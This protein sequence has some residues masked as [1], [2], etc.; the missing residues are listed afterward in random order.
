MVKFTDFILKHR[1]VIITLSIFILLYGIYSINNTPIDAIPDLSDVQVTIYSEWMGQTPYVIENQLTYPLVSSLLGISKV[2]TVRGLSMPNYSLVYVIFEDG[3]DIYWARSRVLE[4]LQSIRSLLPQQAKVE[5]GP[6]AT[7]V[8]WVYQY[9][10]IS[11]NRTLDELWSIQNFTIRYVLLSIPGVAEVAS[12]GGFEKEYRVILKPEKLIFYGVAIDDVGKAI[13]SANIERGGKYIEFWGREFLISLK[14][15]VKDKSDIEN[16][17]VKEVNGTPIKIKDVAL[18][19]ETPSLRMGTAD[20]NGMGNVVGGIVIMRYGANAYTIIHKVKEK[21]NEIQETFKGDIKIIPVYDRSELIESAVENLKEVLIKEIIVVSVVIIIFLLHL[22]ASFVV[23]FFLILSV[24]STFIVMNAL[25]ITSNIMSL[26]GIAVAIGTIV[27][28]S[29]VI[30]E[31]IQR[32]KEEGKNLYTSIKESMAEVGKPIFFSLLIVTVSFVPMLALEGH[33]KRLFSPLVYTKTFSML[34]AS[35]LSILV[36]PALAAYFMKGKGISEE[37]NPVIKL[38]INIYR[39]IYGL[40][41]K[42]R[43]LVL[44]FTIVIGISSYLIYRNLGS[45]FMPDLREGTLLYMPITAPGISIDQVQELLKIQS[46]IIKSFP[47]VESVFGKAGRANTS[48][49]PAPLSMIET[50]IVL[51][52]SKEWKKGITYEKIIEELDKALQIPGVV[53]MWTQP[54]KGRIDM[55]STGIRTPLGI[56]VYGNDISTLQDVLLNIESSL[57]DLDGIISISAQRM[58]GATY[59]EIVPD[60]NLL[61]YYGIKLEDFVESLEVLLANTPITTYISGR[62]RY[63]ITVG[64][65]RDYRSDIEDFVL[66][67]NGKLIPIKAIADI[68]KVEG[69]VEITSENG[70]YVGNIL[71]T[72]KSDFDLDKIIEKGNQMIAQNVSLPEGYHYK[73]SGQYEYWSQAKERLTFIVPAVIIAI[74]LIVYLTFNRLLE[75]FVVLLTLPACVFGGFLFMSILGYKISLGSIGGFLALLGISAE[76]IIIM[77]IYLTNALKEKTNFNFEDAL[78]YGAVKRIRPKVMTMIVIIVGLIP[79]AFF[80]G[81][82]S[83]VMARIAVPMLGGVISSFIVALVCVPSI[84]YIALSLENS[85]NNRLKLS[86]S[87]YDE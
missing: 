82:G 45:E 40:A 84:Y 77:L 31:A 64:I 52:P 6:D 37:K 56:K 42:S 78:Y 30:V 46:K 34:I 87:K 86:K 47:E 4:K 67:I 28:A 59:L 12:V 38:F 35:L 85:L 16:A 65:P 23:V 57:R 5:I 53:N 58:L 10:L 18:V 54:I 80:G 27:D 83:E 63:S 61:S 33:S 73:W 22:T 20:Y 19:V 70:F 41:I 25:G 76:M 2:R 74:F 9:A 7:G 68:R 15:Y 60:R 1:F 62:E 44:G 69:P 24:S 51:K 3:T 49:D 21:I 66:P 32:K 48:T 26:G 50:I 71:I 79:A 8:G 81:V 29:I 55:V 11:E 14:G 75:T 72:P 43:Y 13:S 39:P 17:I 36:V